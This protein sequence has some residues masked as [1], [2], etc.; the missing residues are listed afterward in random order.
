MFVLYDK[1]YKSY[2]IQ[3]N[4]IISETRGEVIY[5]QYQHPNTTKDIN[6]A[7]TFT[8]K[9]NAINYVNNILGIKVELVEHFYDIIKV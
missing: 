5:E 3:I 9:E 4:P 8:T 2:I 1:G 7:K 6:E